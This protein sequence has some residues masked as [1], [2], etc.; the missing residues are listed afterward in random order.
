M[1]EVWGS[2]PHSSTLFRAYVRLQVTISSHLDPARYVSSWGDFK[3]WPHALF[4]CGS[5]SIVVRC[6]PRHALVY[7]TYRPRLFD[8]SG[9]M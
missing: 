1:Q 9:T 6:S 3:G 4:A 5:W 7:A 8:A 2:N